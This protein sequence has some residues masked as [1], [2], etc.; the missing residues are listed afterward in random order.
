MLNHMLNQIFNLIFSKTTA[1][2]LLA[3]SLS[4]GYSSM[5]QAQDSSALS[6]NAPLEFSADN[7]M[8]WD[9]VKQTLNASGNVV[10]KQG[11]TSIKADKITVQYKDGRVLK[12]IQAKTAV[13]VDAPDYTL[14]GQ[15]LTYTLHNDTVKMCGNAK[16]LTQQNLIEGEC[17]AYNIKQQKTKISGQSKKQITAVFH[18]PKKQPTKKN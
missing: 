1:I 9:A 2:T 14:S 16:F 10:L 4:I 11:N 13:T 12:T 5:A 18:P 8:E 17:I 6:A 15:Q 3:L 7:A